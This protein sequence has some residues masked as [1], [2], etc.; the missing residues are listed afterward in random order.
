MVDRDVAAAERLKTKPLDGAR[1]RDQ[2]RLCRDEMAAVNRDYPP[3]QSERDPSSLA[4]GGPH[5]RSE[6]SLCAV[7]R[8]TF[9]VSKVGL[10]R[11]HGPTNNRCSGSGNPPAGRISFPTSSSAIPGPSAIP[12]PTMSPQR[13]CHSTPCR[14]GQPLRF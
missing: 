6:R 10:I 9:Q 14:S 2:A 13:Q 8:R 12:N 4:I 1:C 7:C 3:A 11:L 5:V